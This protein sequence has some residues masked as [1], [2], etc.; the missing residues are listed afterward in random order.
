LPIQK[1]F[2]NQVQIDLSKEFHPFGER[3]KLGD[4]LLLQQDEAF[5]LAGAT[6]TLQVDLHT[7]GTAS[8][9]LTLQWEYWTENQWQSLDKSIKDNTNAFTKD[10]NTKDSKEGN[11]T[12]S[13]TVTV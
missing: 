1:A 10:P 13:F 7:P 6:V 8:S 3:P 5:A 2:T 11:G 4:T 9:D 12:V